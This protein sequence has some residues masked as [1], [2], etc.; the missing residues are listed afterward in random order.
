MKD[1]YLEATR[2]TPEILLS[3]SKNRYYFCGKSAPEDVRS[4][5]YPVLEWIKGFKEEVLL[6]LPVMAEKPL[7]FKIDLAYFNSSSAKF[8][9]DIL[10]NLKELREKEV[11][12]IIEWHYEE[13]DV[14]ILE[15]GEDMAELTGHQFMFIKKSR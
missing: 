3:T 12:V 1:L 4:L 10:L 6:N 2:N 11:P 13:E 5:Y 8:I 14:D 7:V 9:F 15:A